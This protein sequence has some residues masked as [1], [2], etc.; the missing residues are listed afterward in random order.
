METRSQSGQFETPEKKIKRIETAQNAIQLLMAQ[1]FT[2]Y[3]ETVNGQIRFLRENSRLPISEI[4][5]DPAVKPLLTG[6]ESSII[7][8]LATR[9]LELGDYS[10][11][12]DII[13]NERQDSILDI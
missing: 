3:K 2:H 12:L 9:F 1:G 4:N 6:P 13:N 7:R 8:L 11:A 10:E 5:N